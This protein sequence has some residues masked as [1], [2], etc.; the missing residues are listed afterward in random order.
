MEQTPSLQQDFE[1]AMLNIYELAKR[2]HY[3]PIYFLRMVHEY[4]GVGAAKRLL[5]AENAQ[6][7]LF[8][9]WELNKLELSMEALVIQEK[10]APLFEPEEIAT[11]RKRLQDLHYP[12]GPTPPVFA[13]T[14]A[15]RSKR[16][17]GQKIDAAEIARR[18]EAGE[19]STTEFKVAAYWNAKRREKDGT[20]RDN[21]LQALASFMNSYHGGDVFI[22]VENDTSA[23]V[24]LEK[25]YEAADS[26]KRNRDGYELWLRNV[27]ASALGADV[28]AFY[29]I[30]FHELEGKDV[31]LI[32]VD[33]APEPIYL[34]GDLY[35]RDGNGK[36]KLRAAEALRYVEQRWR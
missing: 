32:Q 11:A 4:G 6:Q 7:G 29:R 13:T 5:S 10:Y 21:V 3:Y 22:G 17:T 35:I 34:D 9:L 8:K 28:T 18:I 25:D 27:I 16:T 24:G 23:V 20:M 1:R 14:S 33:P 19:D 2:Y 30:L 36:R 26:G 15:P 12:V 31:L